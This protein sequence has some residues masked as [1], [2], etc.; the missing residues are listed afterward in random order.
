M[1]F[2]S[3][4]GCFRTKRVCSS[5]R[6]TQSLQAYIHTTPHSYFRADIR[7]YGVQ[8]AIDPQSDTYSIVGALNEADYAFQSNRRY[9]FRLTYDN[10]QSLTQGGVFDQ[11][12]T[13]TSWSVLLCKLVV[14]SLRVPHKNIHTG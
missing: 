9:Q 3:Q 12:W 7:D 13:Q 11:I 8:D 4:S 5:H 6:S 14:F 1:A 2:N 10:G